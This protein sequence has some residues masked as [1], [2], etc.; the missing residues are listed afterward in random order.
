MGHSDPNPPDTQRLPQVSIHRQDIPLHVPAA[1]TIVSP[2]GLHENTETCLGSFTC[3][4]SATDS[5]HGG[6]T[7]SSRVKR[8]ITQSPGRDELPGR[9]LRVHHQYGEISDDPQSCHRVSWPHSELNNY[10]AK[11][12]LKIKQIR[13]LM[14]VKTISA[15]NL[16]QLLG[17]MNVTVCVI[18]P[19][20]LFYC[21][22]QVALSNTLERSN[23]NYEAPMT[24]T[25]ECLNEFWVG[26]TTTC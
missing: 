1:R 8:T 19:A 14:R 26:G 13:K 24:L 22:L 12:P 17:K 18:P 15:R 4:G 10:G 20:P 5:L 3:M 21:H 16:A 2:L 9:V 11:P 23:Q 25:T 7:G 6:H